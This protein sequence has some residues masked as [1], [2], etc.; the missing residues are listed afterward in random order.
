MEG[1]DLVG[2]MHLH[3]RAVKEFEV[4]KSAVEADDVGLYGFSSSPSFVLRTFLVICR[5]LRRST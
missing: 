2:C 3:F 5:R 1:T 4:K